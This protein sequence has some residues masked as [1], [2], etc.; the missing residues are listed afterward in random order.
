M[1]YIIRTRIWTAR[2][3]LN[4][5]YWLR[6]ITR[7]ST[8]QYHN[9]VCLAPFNNP[10]CPIL[11]KGLRDQST[12]YCIIMEMIQITASMFPRFLKL[13]HKQSRVEY[14]RHIQITI[15]AKK[16]FHDDNTV[17]A[18]AKSWISSKFAYFHNIVSIKCSVSAK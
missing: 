6:D 18:E 12:T 10:A 7:K 11:Q 4:H 5:L 14:A 15:G 9:Y 1:T 13:F 2:I 17:T 3:G 8:P 16:C